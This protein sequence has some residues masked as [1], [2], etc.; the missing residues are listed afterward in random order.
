MQM[1]RRPV[2]PQSLYR[3]L[4]RLALSAVAAAA[5]LVPQLASAEDRF[6]PAPPEAGTDI[7][8]ATIKFGM[9]PYADNTFYYIGMKKGWFDEVGLSFDPAPYGLKA[10][11][12]NVLTLMLNGQLDM[13]SEYCPLI[14]PTYKDSHSLKCVGF[15]DNNQAFSI[16]ANPKLKLKTFK[17]YIAEGKSFD[18][19]NKAT[20]KPLEGKTLVGA[21]ELSARPFEEGLS[22][23]SGL[24]WKLQVLDDS[25]SLVLAKAG[26]E[27]FVNPEGAPIVYT[28]RQAGWTDLIDIG[29]LVKYGPGGE[30]SPLEGL[31]DIVGVAANGDYINKNQNTVLRFMSVVWRIFDETAKDPSLFD[32][33]AP[34][35]NSFAGT[36]L[37]GKGVADTVNVL[38]P[39]TPF[40]DNKAYYDDP[41][42]LLYY[43]NVWSAIIADLEAH[44]IVPKGIVKPDDVVWGGPIWHQMMDY[45][46]KSDDLFAK[47]GNGSLPDDKKALLDKAKSL[48]NA[49]D[50]LDSYRLA[51]AAASA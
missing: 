29:D 47:L 25:K 41:K 1:I 51:L 3:P 35:L 39:F 26:R 15:T 16:L 38:D 2:F 11:D 43:Q 5:L 13:I 6:V 45:K 42:N 9:R 30:G 28:L 37:D 50:F 20:L 24:K 49:F 8:K 19:A 21:P 18:E 7:P 27:D 14:L 46:S 22:K 4:R 34:Y 32:V 33:Q 36:D 10:N 40:A 17:E 48:Y 31:V 12:S 23:L 44:N